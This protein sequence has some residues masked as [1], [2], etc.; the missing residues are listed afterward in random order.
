M[1]AY[2]GR[3]DNL[4]IGA[5]AQSP[6]FPCQMTV[7]Q[8]K[9]QF[10]KFANAAGCSNTTDQL[11]C[12][13]ETN[14]SVLEAANVASPFPGQTL[15]PDFY[16]SPA[17]DGDLI[18]D[19]P[20]K[21]FQDGRYVHV[22][23]IVGDETNEG[24]YFA[25]NATSAAEVSTFLKANCPALTE[26]DLVTANELYPLM[27]PLP[28]HAAYFPSASAAYGETTFVCAG[29]LM[30]ES[31]ASQ[32]SGQKSWNYR[33]NV[34]TTENLAAGLG[35]PHT[36]DSAAIFG[37]EYNGPIVDGSTLSYETY[38]AEIVPVLMDY[39]LSFVRT[40]DPNTLKDD[41]APVWEPFFVSSASA[42]A[43]STGSDVAEQRLLVETNGTRMEAVPSDQEQRCD[44]WIGLAGMTEQ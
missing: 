10:D 2:G 16:F 37:P 30:S 11:A 18:P 31:V 24:S 26:T 13:R 36:F 15:A 27:P 17:I 4:F 23:L 39:Y 42:G 35:V 6:F 12:L 21:L 22:P 32:T 33:F 28:L 41:S 5:V 7:S 20:Y 3:N 44:F 19:Y 40:L 8:S 29:I 38:N 9:W 34:A 43:N 14:I 1:T 25:A